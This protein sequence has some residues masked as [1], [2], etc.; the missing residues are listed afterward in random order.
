MFS[1]PF[2]LFNSMEHD[3]PLPQE[4]RMRMET[5]HSGV[6]SRQTQSIPLPSS[7]VHRTQSELQLC[8]DMESAERR[9]LS[10]FYRLVNGIRERQMNLVKEHHEASVSSM[11]YEPAQQHVMEAE[12]CLAHIIHTRNAPLDR[13]SHLHH[14]NDPENTCSSLPNE[15]GSGNR[16]GSLHRHRG[17]LSDPTRHQDEEDLNA[18]DWS[19]SGFEGEDHLEAFDSQKAASAV[20]SECLTKHPVAESFA[21]IPRF[22]QQLP[23][24]EDD[25]GIFDL[26]L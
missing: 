21:S 14:S 16:E 24:D 15:R 12:N 4:Q 22:T 1:T 6:T 10:M 23:S 25:D 2:V 20:T 7:H 11:D 19:L 18:A 13:S 9:D 17:A 8:E 5:K 3:A 26:D